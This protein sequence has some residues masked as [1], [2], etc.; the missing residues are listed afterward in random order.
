MRTKKGV[1]TS[2]KMTGTVSVAT[3]RLVFHPIYKKRYRKSKKF[4]CDTNGMDLYEGDKVV[5]EECKPL[6]KN[7]HFKVIEIIKAA[8]RVSEMKDDEAIDKVI[9]REK[10]GADEEAKAKKESEK[11]DSP[12]SPAT[13]SLTT[14]S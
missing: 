8:P 14:E 3:H 12:E 5:I 4:L 10:T 9:H 11:N 2:A 1:I 13:N 7:K 6:S